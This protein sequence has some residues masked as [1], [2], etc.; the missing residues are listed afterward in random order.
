MALSLPTRHLL[1]TKFP[2]RLAACARYEMGFSRLNPLSFLNMCRSYRGL[3]VITIH[4]G[5]KLL[6][7]RRVILRCWRRSSMLLAWRVEVSGC[8]HSG[9]VWR[10]WASF[11]GF[12]PSR[13]SRDQ[14]LADETPGRVW[15][16]DY[17]HWRSNC[18]S[19]NYAQRMTVKFNILY[20]VNC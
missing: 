8:P 18:Y 12:L 2:R 19:D 3:T 7:N 5:V 20:P 6:D 1:S 9:T 11:G 16:G 13:Q 17:R 4:G 14:T 15:S 10:Q